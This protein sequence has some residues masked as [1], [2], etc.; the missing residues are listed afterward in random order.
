MGATRGKFYAFVAV[1]EGW[2]RI[3]VYD[4]AHGRETYL[5]VEAEKF[6][7]GFKAFAA[8]EGAIYELTEHT[9]PENEAC[10]VCCKLVPAAGKT[11]RIDWIRIEGKGEFGVEASTPDDGGTLAHGE[12]GRA[13]P[14]FR[15]LYG[16]ELSLTISS[17]D[18][19]FRITGIAVGMG[20]AEYDD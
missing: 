11:V 7:A 6:A 16:A 4:P 8:K 13:L 9:L 17:R 1:K 5:S 3:Y 20:E 12:A 10:S 14:L 2:R 19:D 15:S 18:P